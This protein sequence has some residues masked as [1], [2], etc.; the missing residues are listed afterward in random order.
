[1]IFENT[2]GHQ[3]SASFTLDGT[4][5]DLTGGTI[6]LRLGLPDGTSADH[7]AATTAEPGQAAYL[8]ADGDLTPAGKWRRQWVVELADGST[9][10]SPIVAFN[11]MEAL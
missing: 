8:T 1:M 10:Y 5:V 2:I 9:Y 3:F 11:V 7:S 6:T 4:A